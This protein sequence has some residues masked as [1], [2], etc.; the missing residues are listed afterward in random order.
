MKDFFTELNKEF[1]NHNFDNYDLIKEDIFNELKVFFKNHNVLKEIIS[2]D[3]I[4]NEYNTIKNVFSNCDFSKELLHSLINYFNEAKNIDNDKFL[5]ILGNNSIYISKGINNYSELAILEHKKNLGRLDLF[6]KIC[7]KESAD[8]IEGS[9]KP[10]IDLLYETHY[11]INS[12]EINQKISF[13]GKIS[14]L[15]DSNELFLLMLTF[16]V[17][18]NIRIN[19]TQLR[20]IAYHNSYTV[21][22][23]D[24]IICEYSNNKS[25]ILTKDN[26]LS[27][28]IF[29]HRIYMILKISYT[30]FSMDNIHSA[31]QYFN[32]DM[33]LTED[34][35]N[36]TISEFSHMHGFKVEKIKNAK[37]YE[38]K[39]LE[40]KRYQNYEENLNQLV[41]KITTLLKKE[42]EFEIIPIFDKPKVKLKVK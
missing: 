21:D 24:Q 17:D 1:N 33:K 26:L 7:F 22:I 19:I 9:I 35:I 13:G 31:K 27:I 23:N 6:S 41:L 8:L 25:F 39:L 32:K 12:K 14:E 36:I 40:I 37:I 10:F 42:T 2:L 30:L 4:F 20:N 38:I 11:L 16:F 3:S 34:T 18:E 29:I 5:K 28:I 15:V